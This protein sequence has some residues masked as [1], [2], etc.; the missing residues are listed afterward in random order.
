MSDIKHEIEFSSNSNMVGVSRIE[1]NDY[2]T[3][4]THYLSIGSI[5]DAVQFHSEHLSKQPF[6]ASLKDNSIS[7]RESES[8]LSNNSVKP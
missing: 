4:K 5:W 2:S 1:N 6:N 8:S 3:R 7:F